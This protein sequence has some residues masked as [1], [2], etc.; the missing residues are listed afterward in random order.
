MIPLCRYVYSLLLANGAL[1]AMGFND[2]KTIYQ[3][4]LWRLPAVYEIVSR[5][6]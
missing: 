2:Y 3:P 5:E 6:K 1:A 4:H